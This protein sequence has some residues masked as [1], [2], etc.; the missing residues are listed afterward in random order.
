MEEECR[1]MQS[2]PYNVKG[3]ELEI[4]PGGI[5]LSGAP[6]EKWF[7]SFKPFSKLKTTAAKN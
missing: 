5:F 4:F 7:W 2:F 1:R 6:E 3:W